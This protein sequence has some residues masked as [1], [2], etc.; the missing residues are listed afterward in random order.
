MAGILLAATDAGRW[1]EEET[2]LIWL[3]KS[4]GVM[5]QPL[6]VVVISIDD[7]SAHDL[8]II[9]GVDTWPRVLHAELLSRLTQYGARVVAFDLIFEDDGKDEVN[10]LFS[11]AIGKAKNIILFQRLR[12]QIVELNSNDNHLIPLTVI[13]SLVPPV[14]VLLDAS[15]GAA[16]FFLPKLPVRVNHFSVFNSSLNDLPTLPAVVLM[17]YSDEVYEIFIKLLRAEIINTRFNVFDS[18]LSAISSVPEH[19]VQISMQKIRKLFIR[20]PE[21]SKKLYERI[22]SEEFGLSE[23]NYKLLVSLVRLFSY[24]DSLYLNFYGPAHTISTVSYTEV[25]QLDNVKGFELFNDKAVF[26]GYSEKYKAEQPDDFYTV[27]SDGATGVDLSGVEIAATAF[28]NLLHHNDL[29]NVTNRIDIAVYCLWGFFLCFGLRAVSSRLIVPIYVVYSLF[30]YLLVLLFFKSVNVWLPV[31]IPLLWQG[32]IVL[33]SVFF[34]HYLD[35]R[36]ERLNIKYAFSRH[37]PVE[38]FD[39]IA[40]GERDVTSLADNKYG[41]VISTDA[42]KYTQL[43]E[44]MSPND[45]SVF[46]NRYYEAI[47][48]PVFES[49]GIITDIV[50]DS[51]LAIWVKDSSESSEIRL[52]ACR[53]ALS[54][55]AAVR[56]F[57]HANPRYN[58]PTRIGIHYGALAVGHIGALDHY[59]YRA[60]GDVV[61]TAS[62]IE[63]LNKVLG[64]RVLATK[65]MIRGLHSLE[66]RSLGNYILVGK[67]SSTAIYEIVDRSGNP[68]LPADYTGFEEAR[69]YFIESQWQKSLDAFT[70]FINKYGNDGPSLFYMDLC[71]HYIEHSKAGFDGIIRLNQNN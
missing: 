23:E 53:A 27:F 62:R 28:A 66:T 12:Q 42:E 56:Q 57:N 47:F 39:D 31:T 32:P 48:K 37:L 1:L 14:P 36:L 6:E 67:H 51:A 10:K 44:L 59:E 26:I 58:I 46:M 9:N 55:Q 8:G 52:K 71:R 5:N 35:T 45:L 15:R 43:S 50:G 40:N 64:T 20:Y 49:G 11:E 29:F 70:L 13:E 16:P 30:Y 2:G 69:T 33:L 4:R 68:D 41:V 18:A 25:L 54:I 63:S 22:E 38:V 60:I 61:N 24:A 3:F 17:T 7:V 65:D 21:L 19:N 34:L